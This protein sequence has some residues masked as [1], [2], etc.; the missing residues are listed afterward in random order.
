MGRRI[1]RHI[2]PFHSR[3][4]IEPGQWQ[5]RYFLSPGR[6]GLDIGCGKGE[7]VAALARLHPSR[8][9]LGVEIRT[10]IATTYFP[11]FADLSNLALLCG[12]INLSL[13]AMCGGIELDEVYINFPDPYSRKQ[14]LKKRRIV[15]PEFAKNLHSAMKSQ[16]I[17]FIQT[18]DRDLFNDMAALLT[19]S[20]VSISDLNRPE[21]TKNPTQAV[22]AWEEECL[23]KG[24]PIYRGFFV[25]A[26]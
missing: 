26:R 19:H 15:T 10:A 13:P 2:N 9:Y 7:F 23:R 14:S 11:L 24:K 21:E 22:T 8:F 1:R 20:F 12:N 18:D 5:D 4:A 17:L 25:K 16:A 6:I 3:V